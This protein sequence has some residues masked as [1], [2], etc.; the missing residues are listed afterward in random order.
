[1]SHELKNRMLE[2]ARADCI[3]AGESG[4]WTVRKW[5]TASYPNL[6]TKSGEMLA[7]Q[8]GKLVK[9]KPGHY[10]SLMRWT[11]ATLMNNH[12]G[13]CVMTD[14]ANELATH[15]NFMLRAHG[16]VLKTGLGLGCVVRG[17]L[18]NPAVESIV[19]IERDP[20]VMRLVAP[21]IPKERVTIIEADALVWC[22][23]TT[24][25]FDCA[26]HDIWNDTDKDEPALAILHGKLLVAMED[27]VKKA[28]GAWAF[29]RFIRRQ[30][31]TL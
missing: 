2:A 22:K 8:Q 25:Q 3:P 30:S 23:E 18:V 24:E 19:V 15:L 11:N 14:T 7:M 26:W 6:L 20:H 27:K 28:H 16:R 4:L 9:I 5:D 31:G 1:M 29:P 12:G 10:T 21:H 17:L 13:E